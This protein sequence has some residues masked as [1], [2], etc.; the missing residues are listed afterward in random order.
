MEEA[1]VGNRVGGRLVLRREIARGGMGIV[2][3]ATHEFMKTSVA[4]KVLHRDAL[5]DP[6]SRARMAREAEALAQ[7]RHR[8]IVQILDSAEDPQF[9][10]FV[11]LEM[12]HGRPLD[13]LLAARGKL[14]LTDSIRIIQQVGD[15]LQYAHRRGVIHR[16]VKPSNFFVVSEN[17]GEFVKLLDFGIAMFVTG[18]PRQ[19]LTRPGAIFGTPEYMAPEQLTGLEAAD[20]RTDEYA[21]AATAYECL[22]G[23]VPF[24]NTSQTL[25]AQH[26][27]GERPPALSAL[28]SGV[29]I[30]VAHAIDRA[31]MADP[32]QRFPDVGSFIAVLSES[33]GVAP[34]SLSLLGTSAQA[35][36]NTRLRPTQT[37]AMSSVD[38][39]SELALKRKFARAPY[40]TPV[41]ISPTDGARALDG[42]SQDVSESGMQLNVPAPLAAGT[43]VVLRF[44]LPMTANLV[45]AQGVIRWCREARGNQFSVG[46]AFEG[47][48]EEAAAAIRRYVSWFGAEADG[49]NPA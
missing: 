42:K 21:L 8:G 16:D 35:V 11:V 4:V 25:L 22:A 19:R 27:R 28:V 14:P 31:L 1:A 47:P 10:P 18:A 43:Q 33:S 44:A 24:E 23:R 37:P 38:V 20:A 46:V 9:G 12:L 13:G 2:F 40:L 5:L 30:S 26:H 48:D 49:K 45:A 6:S 3:E 34:G 36:S 39:A 32:S 15:A 17:G 41:R 29:P 7:V